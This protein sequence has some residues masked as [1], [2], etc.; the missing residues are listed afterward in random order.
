MSKP[1]ASL[2]FLYALF[3][4]GFAGVQPCPG[5][6]FPLPA[7]T[8]G[9]SA[10]SVAL[11]DLNADGVL[12]A[13]AA[14]YAGNDIGVLMGNGDG[15][16]QPAV[17]YPGA[18]AS[19][20]R[21]V[22]IGDLNLDGARD[23]V[24][25][26]EGRAA[27]RV[28]LGNGDGTLRGVV[29]Y[30]VGEGPAM[31][32][33]ADLNLDGA[34]D[35]AVVNAYSDNISLLRGLGDGSFA[36]W[37][38]LEVGRFPRHAAVGDLNGDG[39]PDLVVANA[40]TDDLSLLFNNGD[41]TFAEEVRWPAGDWPRTVVVEDLNRDGRLDLAVA[42]LNGG[43]VS[44][45]PGRGDGTFEPESRFEAGEEPYM[46]LAGD[47]D[48]DGVL[49]LAVTQYYG[50]VAVL[51]GH[52]DGSFGPPSEFLAADDY[53][54]GAAAGDLNRDGVL[55][56]VAASGGLGG[57]LTRGAVTTL[58]G[59]GDGTFPNVI[60]LP[61]PASFYRLQVADFN[62][63]SI[64]DLLVH[65]PVG[66]M[67][68]RG[69]GGF[70]DPVW[71]SIVADRVGGLAAGDVDGDAYDDLAVSVEDSEVVTLLSNGDGTFHTGPR[72]WLG[73]GAERMQ[74]AD[75]N[76]DG[77]NDLATAGGDGVHISLNNG[78][79]TFQPPRELPLTGAPSDFAVG[80]LNGDD[81]PD[82]LVAELGEP[83]GLT[84]LLGN[85][86]GSFGQPVATPVEAYAPLLAIGDVNL[87][88]FPDAVLVD[89]SLAAALILL[90]KGEGTFQPARTQPFGTTKPRACWLGDLNGDR[91]PDLVVSGY[92]MAVLPGLGDGTFGPP[93]LHAAP[94]PVVLV[95]T[96]RDGATDVLAPPWVLLNQCL[97]CPADLNGD[98][99]VDLEDLSAVLRSFGTDAG[100]DADQDGDTDLSDLAILLSALGTACP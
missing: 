84:A 36:D 17:I 99:R 79:G 70:S 83:S 3:P 77:A 61:L 95:D 45:F 85:G 30:G 69:D 72:S 31:V 27:V 81:V 42:N 5:P 37:D 46:I 25:S 13:V 26:L 71:F 89:A 56:L 10:A 60:E 40:E 87:D 29:R 39:T 19:R 34:P 58:L 1:A 53:V 82:L 75:L 12:D 86:D 65:G 80:D 90:G 68:G 64:A 50:A 4:A 47:L 14:D 49:D 2:V 8:V 23:V 98:E 67:L 9:Q 28:Q 62:D 18:F 76:A 51:R 22:A 73:I 66:V 100:G 93:H 33:I 11:A 96:N 78:D 43:D 32:A 94:K 16:F 20:P 92:E 97:P 91:I 63:D 44:V 54:I 7:A 55:D 41:G 35:L 59:R 52:G 88:A 57:P 15:T 21:F 74:L 38:K 24:A 6:L 48:A